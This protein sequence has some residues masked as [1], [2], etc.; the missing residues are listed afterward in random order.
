VSWT[1]ILLLA[2]GT[3]A[4]KA[5]GPVLLGG[6]TLPA[7]VV[8]PLALLPPALLAALVAVQTLGDGGSLTFDARAAGAGVAVLAVWRRLPFVVV[9]LAA[10]AA[11][12][13]ARALGAP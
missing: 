13:L 8:R 5:A 11:A 12:A 3:Y 10:A 1:V 2:A 9:V 7:T 4:L 6:R